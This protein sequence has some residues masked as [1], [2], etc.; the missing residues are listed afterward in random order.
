MKKFLLIPIAAAL[1]L[2]TLI[3]SE[4]YAENQC[5][6]DR[7]GRQ[8]RE[9]RRPRPNPG[10]GSYYQ[11]GRGVDG[12]GHC[13]EYTYSGEILNNGQA[14]PEDLCESSSPS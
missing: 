3:T 9:N 6:R 2:T 10:G 7:D 12:Y 8:C 4:S 11:W 13:Y 14:L 5:R 1:L